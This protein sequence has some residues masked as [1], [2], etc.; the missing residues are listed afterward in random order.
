MH[1]RYSPTLGPCVGTIADASTSMASLSLLNVIPSLPNL[2]FGDLD[3]TDVKLADGFDPAKGL[4]T[5]GGLLSGAPGP[6]R[7][8]RTRW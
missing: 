7:T 6:R 2:P 4:Q 1:A 8:A 5:L 3:L